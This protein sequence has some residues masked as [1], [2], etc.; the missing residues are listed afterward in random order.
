MTPEN[1][2]L[3]RSGGRYQDV[4]VVFRDGHILWHVRLSKIGSEKQRP[5]CCFGVLFPVWI[6]LT[7]PIGVGKATV[8]SG[9]DYFVSVLEIWSLQTGILGLVK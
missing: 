5:E 3:R 7:A 2:R 1:D 8:G 4:A 9:C 6:T